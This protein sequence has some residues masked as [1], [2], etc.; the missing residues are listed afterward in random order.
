[1]N[2]AQ[3]TEYTE[4][5]NI[6]KEFGDLIY[7][8][9]HVFEYKQIKHFYE[10]NICP[11][12]FSEGIYNLSEH[13]KRHYSGIFIL[14]MNIEKFIQQNSDFHSQR[15]ID[16]PKIFVGF[17]KLN[18]GYFLKKGSHSFSDYLKNNSVKVINLLNKNL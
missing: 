1:M 17:I 5:K 6:P 11:D 10:S 9:D 15:S 2:I 12:N 16:N 14:I 7:Y 3:F 13:D 4:L 8:K 18:E